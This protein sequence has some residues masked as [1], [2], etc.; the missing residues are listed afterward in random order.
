MPPT[1]SAQRGFLNDATKR[2]HIV[3]FDMTSQQ[4][5]TKYYPFRDRYEGGYI[6]RYMCSSSN[7]DTEQMSKPQLTPLGRYDQYLECYDERAKK[8]KMM[9][10]D[11]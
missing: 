2:I 6:S 10:D 5:D 1:L 8:K 7:L 9:S 11:E 4:M 3:S